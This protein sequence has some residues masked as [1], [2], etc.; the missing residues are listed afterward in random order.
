MDERSGRLDSVF[1]ALA[2]PTRREMLSRLKNGSMTVGELAEPFEMSRPAISQH[3]KVLEQAGLIE[4]TATAQWRTCTL[5]AEGLDD[6][7]AWVDEHRRGWN[8]RFDLLDERLREL[9]Q[10]RPKKEKDNE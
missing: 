6:A 5:R 8:E 3:L 7:S 10:R 2:D 9:K 4:R 1:S